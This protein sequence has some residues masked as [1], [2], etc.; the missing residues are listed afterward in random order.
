M[1]DDYG[2]LSNEHHPV[3]YQEEDSED[4]TPA[5]KRGRLTDLQKLFEASRNMLD[6]YGSEE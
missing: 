3:S 4:M 6:H 1:K 5:E 2:S